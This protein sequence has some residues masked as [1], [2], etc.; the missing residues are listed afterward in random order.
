MLE[1]V[2]DDP[3][4]DIYLDPVVRRNTLLEAPVYTRVVAGRWKQRPGE[5][6]HPLWKL[7]AQ[8]S[9]GIHLLA[10]GM[11]KSEDEVMQILQAHVDEIDGF[12][13]RT[14]E[15]FDLAHDDIQERLRCLKL[16]LSHPA[17]FDKMLEDRNF[18][19]SIVEGNE[20]IEHIVDRTTQAMKDS[21]KDLQKGLDSTTCLD[22]YL[23]Q[24][25]A[26]WIKQ[27]IEHE[28]VF[29][30]MLG[31]VEGWRKAFQ[32]LLSQGTR[33]G[34]SLK[35]LT[36]II[37]E[38]Q[39]RAGEVSRRLLHQ[40]RGF[41]AGVDPH[42]RQ[43]HSMGRST[44]V[45]SN[46]TSRF[47]A[48]PSKQLPTM[49]DRPPLRQAS[50]DDS[51]RS[52][53]STRTTTPQDNLRRQLATPSPDLLNG[54]P[55]ARQVRSGPSPKLIQMPP[56]SSTR[57]HSV[58]PSLVGTPSPHGTPMSVDE[59]DQPD[60][61][62]PP[63]ELPAHVPQ[64]T[65]L[66]APISKQNR[67]SLGF[68]QLQS[69]RTSRLGAP[70]AALVDLLRKPST[71]KSPAMSQ[72][73]TESPDASRRPSAIDSNSFVGEP[74]SSSTHASL[75]IPAP[76]DDN[77]A[78]AFNKNNVRRP[79]KGAQH[80]FDAH[81]DDFNEDD[82]YSVQEDSTPQVATVTRTIV[83]KPVNLR[84][85]LPGTPSWAVKSF[86]QADERRAE[87]KKGAFGSHPPT[88]P[89][90]SPP[91]GQVNRVP[92]P[93]SVVGPERSLSH[94]SSAGTLGEPGPAVTP[95]EAGSIKARHA[96]RTSE[97]S[98]SKRTSTAA[99][100][101]ITK[102]DLPP[103]PVPPKQFCAEM[104]GS[105][106]VVSSKPPRLSLGLMLELE[107]PSH[108]FQLPPRPQATTSRESL[109]PQE[110]TADVPQVQS[111]VM[112][113]QQHF[114]LPP[115]DSA[116]R[117]SR[118]PPAAYEEGSQKRDVVLETKAVIEGKPDGE[119]EIIVEKRPEPI[120][121]IVR[122]SSDAMPASIY[123]AET[124]ES[125]QETQIQV[126]VEDKEKALTETA[127][128][129]TFVATPQIPL[130]PSPLEEATPEVG[131]QEEAVETPETLFLLPA[132]AYKAPM[133]AKP[134]LEPL[135][136]QLQAVTYAPPEL[137]AQ[138]YSAPVRTSTTDS[139]RESFKSA[140]SVHEAV[141]QSP[142][143]KEPE[144]ESEETKVETSSTINNR[145]MQR[146]NKP[147]ELKH[148]RN[149]SSHGSQNGWKAF[150]TGQPSP[151]GSNLS[152]RSIQRDSVIE[153]RS[154]ALLSPQSA[155]SRHAASPI[156][157]SAKDVVWFNRPFDELKGGP[158]TTS[159]A[160]KKKGV[161]GLGITVLA[162]SE[163]KKQ[164]VRA[165]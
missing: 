92:D 83:A 124:K 123:T 152:I 12:L 9:F 23:R 26:I 55:T 154:P 137:R 86:A 77:A 144:T 157:G 133:S 82:K 25:D 66:L 67:L 28:A 122:K 102:R 47:Q 78:N 98:R 127:S 70:A 32:S 3:D 134:N 41:T 118:L 163:M 16:P 161:E 121:E 149:N 54:T 108:Y 91:V 6:F 10:Q 113:Q 104:E 165:G 156:A 57:V 7:I 42:M 131:E 135:Q 73:H 101:A 48:S 148:T 132:V 56:T 20:K 114:R 38:M 111:I 72:T 87:L 141:T 140:K 19:L 76:P 21:V 71:H 58:V 40:A 162:S 116:I 53:H 160:D 33:L 68:G 88:L 5:R 17:T 159:P 106:P 27:S 164:A 74:P 2:V 60:R 115:R 13:E 142:I 129:P 11:A 84:D 103:L 94:A 96:Y 130:P 112:P 80:W 120:V 8:I 146:D 107:A 1:S 50:S 37:N 105:M 22:S 14:T 126:E 158:K 75:A 143:V 147:S 90:G 109:V 63:V 35:K 45:R 4:A 117:V 18:R 95:S 139:V 153:P 128:Q 69:K 138:S 15:D 29:V 79:K 49:P 85:N 43:A 125:S 44:P 36:D 145:Q 24:L 151:V 34:G 61:Y 39:A 97:D 99:P 110:L 89:A 51:F 46:L 65:M 81:E 136:T 93:L 64:E 59:D 30:A 100:E 52:Q 155:T 119:N 62:F 31:N 150:F